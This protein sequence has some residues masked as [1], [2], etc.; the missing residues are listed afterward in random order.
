MY[1]SSND[2]FFNFSKEKRVWTP[3]WNN[4]HKHLTQVKTITHTQTAE[5][6]KKRNHNLSSSSALIERPLT[7]RHRAKRQC[8]HWREERLLPRWRWRR[9]RRWWLPEQ[10][11]LPPSVG[12]PPGS[13]PATGWPTGRNPRTTWMTRKLE[14]EISVV[15][16]KTTPSVDERWRSKFDQG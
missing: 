8:Q 3:C 14:T 13:T 2:T 16:I 5:W 10:R 11:R 7:E 4:S 12:C 1:S 15:K 6:T 9:R